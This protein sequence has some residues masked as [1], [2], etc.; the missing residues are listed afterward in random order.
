MPAV[1]VNL[2]PNPAL[3]T[4]TTGW[5]LNTG[6]R[7]TSLTGMS[8]TTG[9]ALAGTDYAVSPE[10]SGVVAGLTYTVSCEV[11][12][13]STG[14]FEVNMEWRNGPGSFLSKSTITPTLTGGAVTQVSITAVAPASAVIVC[15]VPSTF[16]A[17]IA[18]DVTAFL[19]EQ[20]DYAGRYFD[21]DTPGAAWA[22][23]PG[24]STSRL[25]Q[26]DPVAHGA[27]RPRAALL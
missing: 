13:A 4:D 9:I 20:V 8:R 1:R 14:T 5:T 19:V 11:K 17:N 2:C 12:Q 3:K 22:S 27:A 7:S 24:N 25:L 16:P 10:V 15:V 26:P 6:P 21:G 18:A 23:T